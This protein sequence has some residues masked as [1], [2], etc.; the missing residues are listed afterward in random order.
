M[1]DY[2]KLKIANELCEKIDGYHFFCD[3]SNRYG[4]SEITLCHKGRY[5]EDCSD[6]DDLINKLKELTQPKPKYEVGQEVFWLVSDIIYTGMV[7][8]CKPNANRWKIKIDDELIE[9]D[10]CHLYPSREA[11]ID[12]QIEY[13]KGLKQ[14]QVVPVEEGS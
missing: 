1:I 12:A 13:W 3:Y 2:E 5:N 7:V 9:I 10:D 14:E 11:L 4:V 6:I 8:C